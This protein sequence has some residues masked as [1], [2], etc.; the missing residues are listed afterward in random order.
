MKSSVIGL[1]EYVDKL[2]TATEEIKGSGR[3]VT[4]LSPVPLVH[5]L[6]HTF[7]E[8]SNPLKFFSF[9][10]ASAGFMT[11][12]TLAVVTAV[13]YPLPR[14]GRA[15]LTVT[16]T[17][18]LGYVFTILF[19]VG[20]TFLGFLYLSGLPDLLKKRVDEPEIAVDA[21]GLLVG[22]ADE[23][24]LDDIERVLKEYGAYEVRRVEE[25]E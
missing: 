7:G 20:L 10:G 12:I 23:G 8:T 2:I 25:E 3:E 16:P 22:G 11:G 6:E 21:F 18:L 24:E 19:G 17:L 4:I 15:I 9:F 5:E 13:L 1:F 14:G